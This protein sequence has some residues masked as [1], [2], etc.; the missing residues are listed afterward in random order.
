MIKMF[1]F[2]LD[3]TLLTSKQ[4]IDD[5]TVEMLKILK[6]DGKKIVIAT[7]RCYSLVEG[8]IQ[9]YDVDCDLILNNGHEIQFENSTQYTTISWEILE[10]IM[11]ILKKYNLHVTANAAHNM[12]Y[13]FHDT[14]MYYDEHIRMSKVLRAEDFTEYMHN[15][16][17]QKESYAKN[18]ITITDISTLENAQIL[19]IDAKTLDDIFL[20]KCI[21]ELKQ[22][23]GIVLSS[24]FEAYV[25]INTT[26][27]DKGR[28]V[29]SLA[30]SYG[31][32]DD[33][34]CAFGDSENDLEML[35]LIPHSF[36]MG[37]A[38]SLVRAAAKYTTD[39]NDNQGVL[40]GILEALKI[41]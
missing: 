23:D 35:T 6:K 5:K 29:L 27:I 24:S 34:I 3:G 10:P 14:D 39:T 18:L 41:K 1:V 37:N 31:I 28:A 16:L 19:K 2:D 13:S 12:K 30:N 21:E 32:K 26:N 25:E 33:E 9:Q 40:K 36:A 20:N 8:I 11:Y 17:F 15:P 38:N 22:I 7:G 4:S